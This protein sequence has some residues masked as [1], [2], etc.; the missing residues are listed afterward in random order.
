ML[1]NILTIQRITRVTGA[2]MLPD[3]DTL[4]VTLD[5]LPDGQYLFTL[6]DSASGEYDR[7][8][9]PGPLEAAREY[10]LRRLRAQDGIPLTASE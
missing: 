9:L 10:L 3:Q 6:D 8:V 4:T 7:R 1:K 5:A 2:E